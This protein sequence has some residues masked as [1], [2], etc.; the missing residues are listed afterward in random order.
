MPAAACHR[1][2][3][4][5]WPDARAR[6]CLADLAAQLKPDYPARWI[7][8][9]RYHLTLCFLG[10]FE[11]VPAALVE[12]A[13][14]AA[15]DVRE[16]TFVWH[17]DRV[18]GFRAPRPP[19]VVRAGI[20]D[21]SLQR[22]HQVLSGALVA[23]GIAMA[24]R[25]RHVAH[26]TLGYGHGRGIGDRDVPAMDFPVRSFVLLHSAPGAREYDELGRWPLTGA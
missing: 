18:T 2:F 24:D 12:H 17:P 8:P 25:R 6:G 3:F 21:A 13:R 4:A 16:R 11:Q 22:L 1:L 23:H 9:S 10:T 19:C 5:I 7:R 14:L 26:V 20:P 15:N